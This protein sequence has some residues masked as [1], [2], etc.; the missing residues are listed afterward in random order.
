MNEDLMTL[1]RAFVNCLIEL[2]R[3]K[4]FYFINF[5]FYS[6]IRGFNLRY[7]GW[8]SML[9]RIQGGYELGWGKTFH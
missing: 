4:A 9:E 6:P 3:T 5:L 2:L 1:N 7:A 8:Y